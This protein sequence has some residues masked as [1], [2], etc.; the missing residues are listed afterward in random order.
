MPKPSLLRQVDAKIVDP[1]NFK[2]SPRHWNAGLLEY[3]GRLWLAYRYHRPTSDS[4]CGIAICELDRRTLKAKPGSQH[5]ELERDEDSHQ[6]DP[7]LFI[8]RGQPYVSYTEMGNYQPG[9][10]YACC[11]KYARLALRG[12]RWSVREIFHPNYGRNGG[13]EREK[14]WVFFESGGELHCVYQDSP[15][16]IVL[17][18]KGAEVKDEWTSPSATWPWGAIR[19]GTPPVPMGDKLLAFFHSSLATEVV[20]H[21]VRYF[22][23][24]YIMEPVAPFRVTEISQRP[25]MSGSESDGHRVDPRYTAGWKP[26][27]VFPCG[28]VP[29]GNRYLVSLGVNDWCI[30]IAKMAADQL[31]LG[32]VDGSGFKDRFF[33][34][35]NGSL[36]VRLSDDTGH[37]NPVEWLVPRQGLVGMTGPG[38]LRISNPRNA[39]ELLGER[40]V[41][42]ITGSEYETATRMRNSH[43][44][45]G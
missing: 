11:M 23:A 8:F 27:V 25:L 45:H 33:R 9:V 34:T 26:Y 7:R 36:G 15:T 37:M 44:V 14:N 39:E 19:G 29:F 16:R 32:P 22:A 40:G 42:E 2:K 43:Y 20:P 21:H 18:L 12:T 38:Y 5:L 10:D 4:R 1:A 31:E 24:A 17:Q 35:T 6:E 41:A 13:M 30:A 3:G 28:C